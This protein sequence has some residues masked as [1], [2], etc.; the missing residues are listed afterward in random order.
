MD[1]RDFL[2]AV[3]GARTRRYAGGESG[4]LVGRETAIGVSG[5]LVRVAYITLQ[6]VA[7][8]AVGGEAIRVKS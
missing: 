2:F 5:D 7:V 1:W 6:R 3:S 8:L 4:G